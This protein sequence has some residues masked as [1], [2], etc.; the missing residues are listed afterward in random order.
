MRW[1]DM[2]APVPPPAED[3][4]ATLQ[5]RDPTTARRLH[6]ALQDRAEHPGAT[7]LVVI[8]GAAQRNALRSVAGHSEERGGLLLGR[9]WQHGAAAVALVTV[10]EAV[11]GLAYDASA[12]S[13]RLDTT[14]WDAA[15][16][17]LAPDEQ[18]VGW[19]HSHPGIGAFFSATDRDT[20][21]AFFRAAHCLGW[22]I[23]P[24]RAE[25]AWFAGA[26]SRS[27]PL[28]DITWLATH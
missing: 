13:L 24:V 25:Q 20:Q 11:P 5:Q 10:R 4:L 21:A 28:S 15:R 22:V 7:P 23:D 16:A 19:Y 18:V 12:V 2:A 3:Y 26:Q 9:P 14:V 8:E 1:R 6:V 27:V 17:Q